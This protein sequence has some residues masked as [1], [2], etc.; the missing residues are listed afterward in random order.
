MRLHSVLLSLFILSLLALPHA[1]AARIAIINPPG[2]EK[3]NSL[4]TAALSNHSDIVVLEREEVDKIFREQNLQVA[5]LTAQEGIHLGGILKADALAL[6]DINTSGLTTRLVDVNSGAIL[7]WT[8]DPAPVMDPTTWGSLRAEEIAKLAV[9]LGSSSTK[10]IPIS[11]MEINSPLAGAK[12]KILEENLNT[13]LASRLL[14]NPSTLVLDRRNLQHAVT[15][16]GFGAETQNFLNGARVIDGTIDENPAGFSLR[17]RLQAPDDTT[18]QIVT[19]SGLDLIDV[20]EKANEEILKILQLPA[21]PW[22]SAEEADRFVK[23]AKWAERNGMWEQAA[24]SFEAAV[25]LGSTSPEVFQSRWRIY[26]GLARNLSRKGIANTGK[27]PE[28]PTSL[29][30]EQMARSIQLCREALDLIPETLSTRP[31]FRN[32]QYVSG[33]GKIDNP[34][35]AESTMLLAAAARLIANEEAKRPSEETPPVPLQ[36]LRDEMHLLYE[37]MKQKWPKLAL[38]QRQTNLPSLWIK[39]GEP[40]ERYRPGNLPPPMHIQLERLRKG[41]LWETGPEPYLAFVREC[42]VSDLEA[43]PYFF[44]AVLNEIWQKAKAVSTPKKVPTGKEWVDFGRQLAKDPHPNAQIGAAV[45]LCRL[46]LPKEGVELFA[47]RKAEIIA[48]Q[49]PLEFLLMNFTID[50]P[51][52]I[53]T[54]RASGDKND[55]TGALSDLLTSLFE[56][57]YVPSTHLLWKLAVIPFSERQSEGLLRAW[58]KVATL[59]SPQ[60]QAE[61]RI[62]AVTAFENGLL[63]SMGR[64]P[65]PTPSAAQQPQKAESPTSIK[66]EAPALTTLQVDSAWAAQNPN[67]DQPPGNIRWA[68]PKDDRIWMQVE[69]PQADKGTSRRV[70][71]S[72]ETPSLKQRTHYRDTITKKDGFSRQGPTFATDGE[73]I[74]FW[75]GKGLSYVRDKQVQELNTPDLDEPLMWLIGEHL[76]ISDKAGVIL[77]YD[78]KK[79][80]TEILASQRRRPPQTTLDAFQNLESISKIFRTREGAIAVR[81]GTLVYTFQEQEKDWQK[82]SGMSRNSEAEISAAMTE[83]WNEAGM[84]DPFRTGEFLRARANRERASAQSA[85][86]TKPTMRAN[87]MNDVARYLGLPPEKA[88]PFLRPNAGCSDKNG[89]WILIENQA[90]PNE[91]TY[92]LRLHSE[93]ETF[94]SRALNFSPEFLAY[95]KETATA[96]MGETRL[97]PVPS[98]LAIY[99]PMDS[100]LWFIPDTEMPLSS[101]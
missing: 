24:R 18:G 27:K 9:K 46:G 32:P 49:W 50:P 95:Q 52:E 68:M 26:E 5:G 29:Q 65:K 4:L 13:L 92:L 97:L 30:L 40:I 42:L 100:L 84:G 88:S 59:P 93:N 35:E 41:L 56:T 19:V 21:R 53:A 28:R 94:V 45:I 76:Y 62:V 74:Y 77:S 23:E 63:R 37:A 72:L 51:L 43:D 83:S 48:G 87:R 12:A 81:M 3:E 96:I 90:G 73:G 91:Q 69:Y 85:P 58:N 6:L 44:Q 55:A 7:L 20:V 64:D 25:A 1:M 15:E 33:D 80:T 86:D 89:I 57:G 31:Q 79:R 16:H 99:H 67:S 38:K 2:L 82:V 17:M 47:Q 36:T 10:A 78:P 14:A 61:Q 22:K 71:L 98:G 66:A 11:L 101:Q 54:E 34:V 60:Q 75:N 8:T 39:E 70:F